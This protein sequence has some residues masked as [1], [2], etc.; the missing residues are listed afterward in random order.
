MNCVKVVFSVILCEVISSKSKFQWICVSFFLCFIYIKSFGIDSSNRNIRRVFPS[1]MGSFLNLILIILF[2][3]IYR[4]LECPTTSHKAVFIYQLAIIYRKY[5]WIVLNKR[6]PAFLWVESLACWQLFDCV[7]G[8]WSNGLTLCA[9]H[10]LFHRTFLSHIHNQTYWL[11]LSHS[12]LYCWAGC[13]AVYA[14]ADTW[15]HCIKIKI[16]SGK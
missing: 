1:K 16:K 3:L 4:R 12:R 8:S 11:C 15:S 5:I 14:F 2:L 7:L 9:C 13:V 6:V 10:R